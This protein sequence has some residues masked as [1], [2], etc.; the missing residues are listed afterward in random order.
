MLRVPTGGKSQEII[1]KK[2]LAKKNLFVLVVAHGFTLPSSCVAREEWGLDLKRME[3][4]LV[5]GNASFS[6][7][8]IRALAER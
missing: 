5:R 6:L 2:S 8:S 7:V 1:M 4:V 3:T